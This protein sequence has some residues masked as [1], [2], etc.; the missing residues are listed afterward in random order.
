MGD[1]RTSE[2][3][4]A[5]DRFADAIS[6]LMLAYGATDGL[7]IEWVLLTAQHHVNDDGTTSTSVG[8]YTQPG[9]PFHRSLGLLDYAQVRL[10]AHIAGNADTDDPDR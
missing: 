5:D 7:L 2:Q 1:G 10:R 4:S 6:E 9:Q 3:K 8:N